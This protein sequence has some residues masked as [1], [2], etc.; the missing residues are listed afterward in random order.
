LAGDGLSIFSSTHLAATSLLP[1]RNAYNLKSAY[2]LSNATIDAQAPGQVRFL[3]LFPS[4][5]L[6]VF[7]VMIG[8]TIIATALPAIAA[9]LGGVELIAWVVAVYMICVSITAPV[10]GRL[11]DAFGRRRMMVVA[12]SITMVGSVVCALSTTIEMLIA[13]RALQGLGGGGLISLS[14]ALLGQSVQPRDRVR[15]HGYITVIGFS[16]SALGP[17]IGGFLTATFGWPS[18]FLF[19]LPFGLIAIPLV[20]RL[21]PRTT[22]FEP[23]RFDL[24][25]LL[26]FAIFVW[27][28]LVLVQQGRRP[29]DIDTVLVGGLFASVVVS[30]LML[31]WRERRA[32]APLF[33]PRLAANPNI[34]RCDAMAACHGAY[35][36]SVLTF[37]PLYLRVV[38][39][40]SIVDIGILLLPITLAIGVG[41]FVTGQVV[42][43]T[44]KSA[45]FPSVG[46][47]VLAM[48]FVV[49]GFIIDSLP[50]PILSAYLGV[51][52]VAM[53][54]VMGVVQATVQSETP[55]EL[56]GTTTAA[57][58]VSRSLGGAVGTALAGALLFA[59]MAATG[60]EISTELQAI[61]Q[62]G[63]EGLSSLGAD[64]VAGIRAGIATAFR[65]VVFLLAV[66]AGISF[67]LAST[68]PRRTL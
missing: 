26:L 52:A 51:V 63:G 17:A 64:A 9:S 46:M 7:L 5:F 44:G 33:P 15:Y 29:A 28:L 4:I 62:G 25:G 59:I 12:L 36:V 1:G 23:F 21:P 39:G 35:F 45:I 3:T 42:S 24:P 55:K 10:Y 19:N 53:G 18:V 48:L 41:S 57:I 34:W 54:T 2:V 50:P 22:Q 8:E 14:L 13:A 49:L 16:A 37:V 38:R 6:P 40:Q 32:S 47:A 30:L 61:L 67:L 31:I 68:L 58:S 20:F 27:S 11:G 66:Y 43:R 65:G 56:L 60:I